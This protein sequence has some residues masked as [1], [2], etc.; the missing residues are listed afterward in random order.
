[1]QQ[2][3]NYRIIKIVDRRKISV[4]LRSTVEYSENQE[5]DDVTARRIFKAQILSANLAK[6]EK[7]EKDECRFDYYCSPESRE[8]NARTLQKFIRVACS[9]ERRKVDLSSSSD[10]NQWTDIDDTLNLR[11]LD[12]MFNVR[13]PSTRSPKYERLRDNPVYAFFP[14]AA[15]SKEASPTYKNC[16]RT[17]V[18]ITRRMYVPIK[19]TK[20]V[21]SLSIEFDSG[22]R[23]V[24]IK[25]LIRRNVSSLRR[26]KW[27][28]NWRTYGGTCRK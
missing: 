23:E 13:D 28:G 25:N 27:L 22:K 5:A 19:D 24:S 21:L 18:F 10:R 8:S 12:G 1:M 14:T 3:K 9:A 7:K 16:R 26:L 11:P 17:I 6:K 2:L 20:H 15:S 4:S